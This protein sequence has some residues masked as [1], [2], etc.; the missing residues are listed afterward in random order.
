MK[1]AISI[2]I[3]LLSICQYANALDKYDKA[4]DVFSDYLLLSTCVDSVKIQKEKDPNFDG[5]EELL[6]CV[7][8]AL[9]NSSRKT[10]PLNDG[11]RVRT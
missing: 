4:D 3:V 9:A 8:E 10:L 2:A 11:A 1:K 5:K 6:K 7:N